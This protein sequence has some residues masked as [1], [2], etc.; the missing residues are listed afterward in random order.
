[1]SSI[2]CPA[3][4]ATMLKTSANGVEV[5]TCPSCESLWLDRSE[6]DQLVAQRFAGMDLEDILGMSARDAVD[7]RYCPRDASE[8]QSVFFQ[9]IEL[10]RCPECEGIFLDGD[11]RAELRARAV[12]ERDVRELEQ[13]K[14][15]ESR[16]KIGDADSLELDL[17]GEHEPNSTVQCGG[18]AAEVRQASCIRRMDAYW[19]EACVVAGD[20]PGGYGEPVAVKVA[21]A[22]E[23]MAKAEA[24]HKSAKSARDLRAKNRERITYYRGKA[25]RGAWTYEEYAVA[26]DRA[27]HAVRD[28]FDKIRGKKPKK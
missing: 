14:K 16:P 28:F 17:P 27:G 11:D 19:C 15:A 3:C 18:C 2:A 5:D 26:F 22:A 4:S 6:F 20:Y 9:E 7:A 13:N 25:V 21:R 8:M 1:M 12:H 23:A 10:D 24:R